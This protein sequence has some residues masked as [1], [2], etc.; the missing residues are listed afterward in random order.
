MPLFWSNCFAVFAN[1]RA[2]KGGFLIVAAAAWLAAYAVSRS[3]A[4]SELKL[5]EVKR[6]GGGDGV[7]RR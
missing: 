4:P 3:L 5:G 6:A 1:T 2:L 7:A